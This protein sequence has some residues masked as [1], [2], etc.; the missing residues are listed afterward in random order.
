ME[1]ALFGTYNARFIDFPTVGERFVMRDDAFHQ[2]AGHNN[3]LMLGP[4]GSGKTTLLKMLKIGAQIRAA[5]RF[6]RVFKQIRYTPVYVGADRQFELLV[7]GVGIKAEP[8]HPAMERALRALMTIRVQFALLD[9]LAE[10]TDPDTE[11]NAAVSH[12]FVKMTRGAEETF[13]LLLSRAWSIESDVRNTMELRAELW[14]RIETINN[15]ISLSRV[16]RTFPAPISYSAD[17]LTSIAAFADAFESTVEKKGRM[18]CLCVDELEIMPASIQEY[19]Y[20][21]LRST[22]QNILLKLATSPYTPSFETDDRG[23]SPMDGHDYTVINLSDRSRSESNKFVRQLVAKL[24]NA[25][26]LPPNTSMDSMLGRSPITNETETAEAQSA[27]RAPN[28]AHYRRFKELAAKN[29][30]FAAYLD[31]RSIDIESLNDMGESIKAAAARKII[32]P[33][34]LHLVYGSNQAFRLGDVVANRPTSTKRIPEYY[35]GSDAIVTM[36]DGNPRV[37]IGL[38]RDLITAYKKNAMRRVPRS[39]QSQIVSS[40]IDKFLSLL[41]AIPAPT[42]DGSRDNTSLFELFQKI[43]DYVLDRNYSDAFTPEL[44]GTFVVD[45]RVSGPLRVAIGQALNQGAFV[46][47]E[48]SRGDAS[49]GAIERSRLRVSYLLSPYFRL[50]LIVASPVN[51]STV[52]RHAPV[53]KKRAS[54]PPTM[55]DLFG[56]LD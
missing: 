33:V 11:N 4:R 21:N 13:C 19:F 22:H 38:F 7:R 53:A 55:G 25:E 47:I 56:S 17:P 30:T 6:H 24:L 2:L 40:A 51:L 35:T 12:Q 43:S 32:W 15:N 9:T 37:T 41:S 3:V 18:W 45:D 27:Y 34:A 29:N 26:D 20:L 52:L 39:V 48:N 8:L 28:G 14:A 49:F 16:Q 50:P 31:L 42:L 10:V 46:M 1:N 44:V 36:C 54:G 5:Q 23:A